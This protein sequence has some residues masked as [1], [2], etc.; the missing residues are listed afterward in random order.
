MV[1]E[2]EKKCVRAAAETESSSLFSAYST[3]IDLLPLADLLKS[4]SWQD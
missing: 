4:F 2:G 3:C 1:R